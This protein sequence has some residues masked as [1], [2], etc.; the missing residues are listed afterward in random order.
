M[1]PAA[2][3][4]LVTAAC[5]A[6]AGDPMLAEDGRSLERV[7]Q[8]R[9][10]SQEQYFNQI[11]DLLGKKHS[12]GRSWEA[13]GHLLLRMAPPIT[14]AD[15]GAG[16]GMVSHLLARRAAK[17]YCIDNSPRMVAVGSELAQKNGIANIHY[18]LGDIERAP[19]AAESVDL[20]ILSQALHH[21]RH[22]QRAVDEAFRILRPGGQ[23]LILDLKAHTFEKARKLYSDHWLGFT[24]GT[25]HG[26]LRTA[27]FMKVEIVSVAREDKP[28]FF[29]TLLASGE[30]TARGT[31]RGP[32]C[33]PAEAG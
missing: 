6:M 26:F 23:L 24:E 30:K 31:L 12:P 9:R 19:L 32:G 20:A 3:R 17:V 16:E 7:L 22:P 1:C 18:K 15:L 28:P 4:E 29:E 2:Q 14:I 21:A 5:R 10:D 13:I 33:F 11:A 25:L 27:G 8:R